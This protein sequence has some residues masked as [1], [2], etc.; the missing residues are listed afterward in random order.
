MG[1][2]NALMRTLVPRFSV[3][4]AALLVLIR[5]DPAAALDEDEW[6]AAAGLAGAA[7]RTGGEF[8]P[9]VAGTLE[10]QRGLTD[11]WAAR[12][13]VGLDGF[14]LGAGHWRQD[15]SLTLGAALAFDVL[16]TVPF[17]ELG[18]VLAFVDLGGDRPESGACAGF[19]VAAGADYLLD[20][21]W[22]LGLV[23]RG[24]GLPLAL[25]GQGDGAGWSLA[26]S[27]RL[28]RRF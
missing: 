17:A 9:G 24:R 20:Q 4:L 2:G 16:R 26:A 14:D 12:G 22:A 13:G 28:A 7:L 11:L 27:V 25:G 19:E 15:L 8:R 6:L 18:L 5:A 3:L 10:V 1:R 23:V 21:S